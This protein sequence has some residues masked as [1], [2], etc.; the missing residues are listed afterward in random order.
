[1]ILSATSRR[2]SALCVLGGLMLGTV[3]LPVPVLGQNAEPDLDAINNEIRDRQS[4]RLGLEEEAET[5][6][7]Q[8]KRLR[9]RERHR[10]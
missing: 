6:Q 4:R 5:I 8:S 1:M 7:N 10:P 3:L 9:R 2:L